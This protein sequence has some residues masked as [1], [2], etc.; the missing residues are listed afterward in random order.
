MGSSIIV[1]WKI[2][3]RLFP[4]AGGLDEGA[5]TRAPVLALFILTV[6]TF[7]FCLTLTLPHEIADEGFHS[8]VIYQFF[9]GNFELNDIVTVPPVYHAIIAGMMKTVDLFTIKFARFLHLLLCAPSIFLFFGICKALGQKGGDLRTLIYLLFPIS[10]PFFVLI[11]TD[12]PAMLFVLMM[13]W[14]TL[15]NHHI[16]AGL[17]GLIAVFARQMNVVWL[18]FSFALILLAFW[19][20]T[21]G[22]SIKERFQIAF[23]KLIFVLLP[24]VLAGLSFIAFVVYNGNILVGSK[25]YHSVSLNLS[26]LYFILLLMFFFLLPYNIEY[27][28]PVKRMFLST[29]K[30]SLIVA[31]AF[32]VYMFTY[33]NDH[34]FNNPGLSFYLRNILL[35]HTTGNPILR[36]L[37]FV[38][39]IW[40][41]LTLVAMTVKSENKPMLIMLY[42]FSC[43]SF[44]PLPLVE[45]RYALIATSLLFAFMPKSETHSELWSLFLFTPLSIVGLFMI[46]QMKFFY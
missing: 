37:A 32:L 20:S 8:P 3:T 38:P 14:C 42:I 23:P 6:L 40:M 12:V 2:G 10:L 45:Q 39:M 5:V 24:Y 21:E 26:N 35:E 46:T 27:A 15:R 1:D 17:A 36:V 41:A 11:Y 22:L 19:Q 13:L 25:Q 18:A 33:N 43:L 31:I 9:H 16:L 4:I 29:Y 7:A 44:V 34:T 28:K 30:T